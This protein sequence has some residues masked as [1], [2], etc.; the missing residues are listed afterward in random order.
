[1]HTAVLREFS[2]TVYPKTPAVYPNTR[3]P[4]G[5]VNVSTTTKKV[6]DVLQTQLKEL[7][8]LFKGHGCTVEIDEERN[9]FVVKPKSKL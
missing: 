2:Q 1:M 7:Q 8:E 3:I 6:S 9:C 4:A 5:A